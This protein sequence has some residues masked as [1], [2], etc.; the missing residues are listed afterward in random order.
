MLKDKPILNRYLPYLKLYGFFWI[1]AFLVYLKG[2]DAGWSF[3]AINYVYH[4]KNRTLSQ[5]LNLHLDLSVRYVYHIV[6]YALYKVLGNHGIAW[7]LIKVSGHAFLTLNIFYFIN[8]YLKIY[9][10]KNARTISILTSLLFLV[11]PYNTEVVL[12]QVAVYYIY[13]MIFIFMSLNI[14]LNSLV[15]EFKKYNIIIFIVIYLLSVF[16]LEYAFIF[17]ILATIIIFLYPKDNKRKYYFVFVVIPLLII[18]LYLLLNKIKLNTPIGHYGTETHFRFTIA[19]ITQIVV[20]N[21]FDFGAFIEYWNMDYIYKV[22]NVL[23]NQYNIVFILICILVLIV[24]YFACIKKKKEAQLI[25]TVL[26]FFLIATST[27]IGLQILSIIPIE[28]DRYNYL[29]APFA[30]LLILL[31]ANQLDR[32]SHVLYICGTIWV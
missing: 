13:T 23:Y 18:T 8:T 16:S 25:L 6:Q 12:N 2:W 3:D 32:K 28:D 19:R 26:V 24:A 21:L 27:T 4:A 30:L 17:P 14:L 31:I 20:K 5:M 22:Y 11:S 10:M 9:S 1:I 7:Y 15:S 29:S